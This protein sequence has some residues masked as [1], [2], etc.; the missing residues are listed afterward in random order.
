[1]SSCFLPWKA[2]LRTKFTPFWQKHHRMPPSKTGWP[3]FKHG[4]FSICD[5]RLPERPKRVTAPEI[6]DQIDEL[7]LEDSRISAK[8][9]A[10]HLSISREWVQSIIHEDLDVRKLS[11]KWVPKCLNVNGA[12]RR[13]NFWNFFG[14][15]QSKWFPVANGDHGQNLVISLWPADT[16]QSMAWQHSGSPRSAPKI[17]EYKN[18]LEKFLSWTLRK[19]T[20]PKFKTK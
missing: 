20:G 13:R 10:E 8:S 2:R 15:A 6:I 5:A 9:I 19:Q 1:M 17:S 7:I 16:E 11:A 4:G 14:Y 3:L 12:S 18:P